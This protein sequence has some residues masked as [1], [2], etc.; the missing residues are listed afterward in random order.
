MA[1]LT[2]WGGDLVAMAVV[3]LVL[4]IFFFLLSLVFMA[5]GGRHGK[6]G[7]GGAAVSP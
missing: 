7:D 5:G 2:E 4:L 6:T 1:A 3:F